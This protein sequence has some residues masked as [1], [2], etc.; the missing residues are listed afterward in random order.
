MD[1]KRNR[2][3]ERAPALE[4]TGVRETS[5]TALASYFTPTLK[6]STSIANTAR[7]YRETHH[8]P[9]FMTCSQQPA[10]PWGFL[11]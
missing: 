2:Q 7:K 6:Q 10:G 4:S 1:Q 8:V 5:V 3:W 11:S 9:C